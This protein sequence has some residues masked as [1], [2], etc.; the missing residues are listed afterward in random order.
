M[1]ESDMNERDL[2][3]LKLNNVKAIQ[4][5]NI[6]FTFFIIICLLAFAFLGVFVLC[7]GV[8]FGIVPLLC[9]I[10]FIALE[11]AFIRKTAEGA[12][13]LRMLKTIDAAKIETKEAFCYKYSALVLPLDAKKYRAVLVGIVV[14]T[15]HG[16]YY[17]LLDN[18]IEYSSYTTQ[19]PASELMSGEYEFEVYANSKIITK[20]PAV[21]K[22]INNLLPL[23]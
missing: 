13:M 5:T 17:Y 9:D 12:E 16:K 20:F 15:V 23:L 19:N 6:F 11:V 10:L 21:D 7:Y 1:E 22:V 4:N 14:T 3:E 18:K 8:I 2:I